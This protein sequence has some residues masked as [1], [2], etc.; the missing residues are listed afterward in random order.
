M[1]AVIC[2][3]PQITWKS[4]V[5]KHHKHKSRFWENPLEK[6]SYLAESHSYKP[7]P[8]QVLRSSERICIFKRLTQSPALLWKFQLGNAIV[9]IWKHKKPKLAWNKN[10]LLMFSSAN[11]IKLIFIYFS[12]YEKAAFLRKMDYLP[13]MEWKHKVTVKYM[14]SN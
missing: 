10:I 12:K 14:S 9:C 13:K 1:F 6:M 2:A 4:C 7:P 8:T 5:I 11:K 3:L